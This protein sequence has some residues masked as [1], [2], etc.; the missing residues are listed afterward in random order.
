MKSLWHLLYKG[1]FYQCPSLTVTPLKG[2]QKTA[3]TQVQERAG[4]EQEN[5]FSEMQFSL[6]SKFLGV[7]KQK[8]IQKHLLQL[9]SHCIINIL[10]TLTVLSFQC[11][12][13][14]ATMNNVILQFNSFKEE[15]FL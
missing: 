15:S 4:K 1:A 2:S 14:P 13:L 5:F 9:I 3:Q 12:L 10:L 11:F 7:S 8:E 6:T